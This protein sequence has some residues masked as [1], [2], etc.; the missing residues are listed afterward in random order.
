MKDYQS[1]YG[2][3]NDKQRLAV[4]TIDGPVLVLAGPGTGKTQLLSIRAAAILKE[5]KASCENILI[6]TYTNSAAKAMKERLAK[7]VGPKG[8]DIEVGTFHSFANS[9]IQESEEAAN[10]VGDKIQMSDVEQV[11]ALEHALDQARG[12][13]DIRPFRA[14]Y[15]YVKEIL[16]KIGELKRDGI[17]P[18][19][20]KAYLKRSGTD[21][22]RLEEKQQKR[23]HALAIVYE[24]YEELKDGKDDE[25]F[26]ARGRYDFDDMILFA[27]EAVKKEK[28]LRERYQKL[29]SY[30]MVDEYQDTNGAQLELLFSILDQEDPNLCCVGDDDQ[31]IYR[32]Q[33]ASVGNFKLLCKRF[34]QIKVVDLKNNYRSS[35][36]LIDIAG[37]VIGLIPSEERMSEKELAAMRDYK[38]KEIEFREFT[39]PEE[40]LL[41]VVGKIGDL[42]ARIEND[43]GLTEEERSH[44]Y[45]NIAILVRKRDYIL[46]V[47]DALLKAG[48]PYATDGK[49]DIGG[50]K[51][52][53]QLLDILELAHIKPDEPQ[54]KDLALYK[55]LCADYLEIPYVDILRL[56]NHVNIKREKERSLNISILGELLRC[57]EPGAEGIKFENRKKMSCAA[58]AVKNLLTDAHTRPV[59]MI[60]MDFINDAGMFRYILRRYSDKKVL[61]IRD[62]RAITSFINMVKSS[63]LATPAIRLDDFMQEI[64]TRNEHGLAIQGNLV[65]M[66]QDG[67]RVFTAHGSK[68]QEYHS[69]IMPFCLQ[70]KSWPIRPLPERIPLPLD[71][72]K[73]KEA[74]RSKELLKQLYLNDETRLFY[75][76]MTRAR[77]NLIFTASPTEAAMP[78]SYITALDIPREEAPSS[79]EE[80]ILVRVLERPGSGDLPAG[81]EAVLKDMVANLSLNPTRLNTYLACRRKFLYN[82]VLKLPGP[83]KKSLIFGNCVH[84]ALEETYREYMRSGRF[85]NFKY[86]HDHFTRELRFQGASKAIEM[87]CLSEERSAILKGW[88]DIASANPVMPLSLERKLIVTVGDGVIFTGK[89]DKMEWDDERRGLV[90]I[91]DYKTGKPDTH[92]KEIGACDDLSSEDC[93]DYLRQIVSYKLLFEKDR[94]ESRGR[95]VRFGSLVF[96]EPLNKDLRSLGYKKGDYVTKDIEIPDSLVNDLEGI[97]KDTWKKIRDLQFEKLPARDEKKCGMCNFDSIC[98]GG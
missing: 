14:P 37:R 61:R 78:S 21:L 9:I 50:E 42:K 60:L 97:I 19:D 20:F 51:R 65:T 64:E 87:H 52:V 67:V 83:K 27:T 56:V 94:K 62:L 73:A 46:Q 77:A 10:Y 31:S 85:P 12:V 57:F 68:G 41:Y 4:D 69:V 22:A 32:F 66:T 89:Y 25:I 82:D 92:L 6:L 95:S 80:D 48:I 98:W 91:L 34:P 39:T 40:E 70:N 79:A 86:F 59:H 49:E 58:G 5:R 26:D 55:V 72:F 75:V 47:V 16:K 53:K 2:E 43:K 30:V 23:V 33:G 17:T 8:Y 15:L 3:L 35:A 18:P 71:L 45:N 44:P 96:L 93:D 38:D 7:I 90:R 74:M 29:Y 76:A 54:L 1:Y 84:K 13:E 28:D 11:K 88:F 81:T 36:E 63:D 24:K